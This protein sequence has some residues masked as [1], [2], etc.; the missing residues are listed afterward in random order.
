MYFWNILLF[1]SFGLISSTIVP[2]SIYFSLMEY[3]SGNFTSHILMSVSALIIWAGF[4]VM[5]VFC[6]LINV[7]ATS[8]IGVYMGLIFSTIMILPPVL[9]F[10]NSFMYYSVYSNP[11][12]TIF[13]FSNYVIVGSLALFV[14]YRSKKQKGKK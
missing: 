12:L 11:F 6:Y 1:P 4:Y 14:Y 8:C 3:H 13:L 7:K 2:I 5:C 9:K 10:N